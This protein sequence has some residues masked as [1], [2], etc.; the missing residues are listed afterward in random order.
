[1]LWYL[2]H[3]DI[4]RRGQLVWTINV[5]NEI[6]VLKIK[7][8]EY[9]DKKKL[10][11]ITISKFT[12]HSPT[13]LSHVKKGNVTEEDESYTKS[14]VGSNIQTRAKSVN[15]LGTAWNTETDE[16][17]F[18]LSELMSLAKSLPLTKRSFLRISAKIFDPL[19][20][21]TPFTI[22]LKCIFQ[23]IC[24]E[25]LDWDDEWQEPYKKY[26]IPS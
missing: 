3:R 22:V 18:E 26:G 10:D 2:W 20:I 6:Y 4:I 13:K 8:L 25:G 7:Q 17:Q 11:R 14:T 9:L 19:G 12:A 15:V 1:M 23:S 16:F 21:L 24:V 5:T